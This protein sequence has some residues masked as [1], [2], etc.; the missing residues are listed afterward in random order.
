MR[1]TGGAYYAGLDHVRALAA[2]LVVFWHFAHWD[3]GYPV[4]FGQA[5]IL[6]PLDEGHLGV[7]LF[8]TLSGYLF[9]KLIGE[10]KIRYL[11]FLW[12]RGIRLIPLLAVVLYLY[13]AQRGLEWGPYFR[14]LAGGAIFPTLPNAG[15]S[16]TAEAHFY[17]LLPFLLAVIRPRPKFVLFLVGASIALRLFLYFAGFDIQLLAYRTI[18]GRFDQFALGIA[19]YQMRGE[20]TGKRALSALALLWG[21]YAVFDWMGGYYSF[22]TPAVWVLLPT[23]EGLTI[24]TMIAWYDRNPIQ[25]RGMWVVRKAG[26]Y[27]YSVYLLHFFVVAQAAAFVDEHV[28]RMPTVLHALPWGVLFFLI[29]VAVGHVSWRLIEEPPLRLRRPYFAEEDGETLRQGV[30]C[31]FGVRTARL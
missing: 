22:P 6:A 23:I 14:L 1:S 21:S 3:Q 16:I 7:S 2:F 18:L 19:A 31:D 12:N 27:S 15:W 29:M 9:A 10:R 5:S 13:A 30:A 4:P 20:V 26:E 28:M 8:M 11:P 17:L 25:W 24:A